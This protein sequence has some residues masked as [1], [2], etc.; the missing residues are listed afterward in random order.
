MKMKKFKELLFLNSINRVAKKTIYD[1][2]WDIL[3]NSK[4]FDDL[5]TKMRSEKSEEIINN[6][7]DKMEKIYKQVIDDSDIHIITCF[8]ENYPEKL[9]IMENKRPLYLFVKGNVN[10][11]EKPNI[12]FIG[13]R[14]PS[15]LSEIFEKETVKN[16]VKSQDKVIISGL[17]LG[18]DKIAHQTTVDE[19]KTTIAILP[20]GVNKITPASNK[21]L[22]NEILENGGCLV[23]EYPPNVKA[24][25]GSYLERDKIVAA[26]SDATFVVE[27]G[28]KSGTMHTVDAAKDF[29]RQIYAYLPDERPEG[30]YDG[31]ELIL[32][33]IGSSIK[34]DNIEEFLEDL[35]TLKVDNKLKSVQ[36]TLM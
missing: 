31:N 19:N 22:A 3:L 10:A 6:A 28:V 4:D 35:K 24:N 30:S 11:L 15:Q 9:N 5:V 2:Y 36:L 1:K 13:T 17:A 25:R 14:N 27:C 21:K 29:N 34:V 8:D 32:R 20:S 33:N 12:A 23:S 7:L 16:I 26:F 18:C